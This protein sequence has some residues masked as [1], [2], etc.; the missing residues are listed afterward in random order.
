MPTLT[1]QGAGAYSLNWQAIPGRSYFIQYS[2]DLENWHYMPVIEHDQTGLISYGF[3]VQNSAFFLRLHYADGPMPGGTIDDLDG[4][5][6]S[7]L[8][9]IAAG[10][11]ES[12]PL[13]WDSNGNGQ[14]DYFSDTDSNL[15]ADGWELDHFGQLGTAD[16]T[17]DP[18]EDGI[19][20]GDES[21]LATDPF[22]HAATTDSDTDGIMDE[23][24]ACP[25]DPLI[26]WEKTTIQYVWHPLNNIPQNSGSA[27][28]INN[29]GRVLFQKGTWYQGSYQPLDLGADG[30]AVKMAQAYTFNNNGLIVGMGSVKWQEA[31]P[32]LEP[33][34]Y[35]SQAIYWNSPVA[36]PAGL[37][38]NSQYAFLRQFYIADHTQPGV[39]L[40]SNGKII[41]D[42]FTQATIPN[43][44][45]QLQG[46]GIWLTDGNPPTPT[47]AGTEGIGEQDHIVTPN[48]VNDSS[49][50]S[51]L[52][53][54]PHA[55]TG[56]YE[57]AGGRQ[58]LA[59][60][61]GIH[62]QSSSGQW[63]RSS[64]LPQAWILS[65][66]GTA[67]T[68][69]S[70]PEIWQNGVYQSIKNLPTLSREEFDN[71]SVID[72]NEKGAILMRG[73]KQGVTKHGILLPIQVEWVAI[74]GYDNID[75]HVDP[76]FKV[77][78]GKRIFPGYK[79]PGSTQEIQHKVTLKISGGLPGMSVYGVAYDIDDSTSEKWDFTLTTLAPVIDVN[80]S[81]GSDNL[82]D[83]YNIP[84]NGQFWDASQWGNDELV[85][86]LNANGKLENDFRVGMQPGNNYRVVVF[87]GA[88]PDPNIYG[89][90][91][92]QDPTAAN[93]LS[94][95]DYNG[96]GAV[97]PA[98]TVWRKLWI[99][100]DSMQAIATDAGG[101]KENHLGTDIQSTLYSIESLSGGGTKIGIHPNEYSTT[102]FPI[103]NGS[104][105]IE[106]T[107][108]AIQTFSASGQGYVTISE[109]L[110]NNVIGKKYRLYDDDDYALQNAPLP[111]HD[112]VNNHFKQ[113][114]VKSFIE[115]VDAAPY[116][117]DTTI[118]FERH[119]DF[120]IILGNAH[121][122]DDSKNLYSTQGLWV[123]YLI[124]AY[125]AER[126]RCADPVYEDAPLEGATP[127]N[128]EYSAVF[129]EAIREVNDA[130]FRNPPYLTVPEYLDQIYVFMTL[131]AAHEL[132]HMPGGGNESIHHAELGLLQEGG[133]HNETD[134]FSAA[135]I[136]RFRKTHNWKQR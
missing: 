111:R 130:F 131:T 86:Q 83:P 87:V 43:T 41:A 61:G 56:L 34:K 15:L 49:L 106:N 95:S 108:Y 119:I 120:D 90:P 133:A 91:Q 124:I 82:A 8:N 71:V 1:P 16:P 76:W 55:D 118:D 27:R 98:L 20:N 30:E 110:T 89:I 44:P 129:V 116:N 17:Y 117:T 4:D 62:L 50:I 3:N 25:G 59:G 126:S 105:Q 65:K 11:T 115:V 24:D 48:Y 74:P 9:E 93:Y 7:N 88:I 19:S 40:N 13:S 33:A 113:L 63:L 64:F 31:V 36:S 94:I 96:I 68:Q 12:S 67:I 39:I 18:D 122:L 28:K 102:N 85:G 136:K 32:P 127:G 70:D 77:K 97:S 109:N 38:S 58:A 5:G 80:G 60:I 35:R 99:E 6:I 103:E 125:Q 79:N 22:G 101:F 107:R 37:T 132:A 121:I 47:I 112:F 14:S 75:D 128:R 92:T 69:G 21:R 54:V 23:D 57:T 29:S 52:G 10:G 72:M 53:T 26:N 45:D 100:N 135:S 78:R 73:S 42:I 104:I 114:F 84:Q 2:S 51:G 81:N 66:S 123:G 46:P 134:E